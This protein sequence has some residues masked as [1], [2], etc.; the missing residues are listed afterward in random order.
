MDKALIGDAVTV[1][2]V[3]M[4]ARVPDEA[5]IPTENQA[6]LWSYSWLMTNYDPESGMVQDRSR[7]PNGTFENVTATGKAAKIVYYAYK[8]GVSTY[9]N[10]V[11]VITKIADTLTRKV[12]RGPDEKGLWPHFTSNGGSEIKP[13]TEWASGDTAFAALDIITA[14]QI[15]GDPQGQIPALE[16]FLKAIDWNALLVEDG[17]ISHGFKYD[18]TRISDSWKGFGMETMGVNWAYASATGNFTP[19]LNPPSDN[20]SGFI[21]QAGFPLAFSGFDRW[22][23][24]WDA[25]RKMMADTQ[26]G[27]YTSEKN[28]YLHD[29]GLFGLSAAEDPEGNGYIVYGVGGRVSTAEDGNGEVIVLHYAGMIS[30]IRLN[31]AKHVWEALRDQTPSFFQNQD[32]IVISPLNNM[33]SMRVNKNNG[34]STINY[35]KGSW[36]LALQAEGWALSDPIIRNDLV[37]AIHKNA[38]LRNG[39]RILSRGFSD[40]PQSHWADTYIAAIYHAL[41]TRGCS[42]NPLMYCPDNTVTRDQMAAFII[43]AKEGEN[44]SYSSGPYFND[45]PASHWAF[46]Y[47]QRL[48][49]L[50]ITTGCGIGNYCPDNTVTRDQMAAFL[51]RAKE[52][53]DFSYSTTPYFSDVASDYWAFKYIQRL[54]ELGITT[55]CASGMYCPTNAVTRDQMAA[56]LARAFLGMQ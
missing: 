40:V 10:A 33:E 23:N 12:T 50:G 28:F 17:T 13:N 49:E 4:K 15:I 1:D 6:F 2:R 51:V 3:G 26:I 24:D 36:N 19:M 31:Q 11:A 32:K 22:G 55:G 38:F 46:K 54:K 16:N 43:R 45:V 44:F 9:E 27:W 39:Y 35:L 37:A 53:E 8:K 30:D 34:S 48:K 18:K 5:S 14:L 41:I 47:I 52:G 20:G 7:F 29:A 21:D 25:Y 56:F 42:Q